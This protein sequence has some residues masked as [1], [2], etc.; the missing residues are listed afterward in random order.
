MSVLLLVL[1]ALFL[2][3]VGIWMIS[4]APDSRCVAACH[5][6]TRM[7]KDRH[8]RTLE[9]A[10]AVADRRS[11]ARSYLLNWPARLQQ[12]L[13]AQSLGGRSGQGLIMG[14]LLFFP[15]FNSFP[16]KSFGGTTAAAGKAMPNVPDA[17]YLLYFLC[18]I[19]YGVYRHKILN[20]GRA[21]LRGSI[22]GRN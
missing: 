16:W 15:A 14:V 12:T 13:L 19:S 22:T 7:M 1:V 9:V 18:L 11:W 17:L 3:H 5:A 20:A 2:G 4:S 21:R 6:R 10:R 8:R